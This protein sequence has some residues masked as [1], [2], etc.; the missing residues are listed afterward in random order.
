MAVAVKRADHDAA[1]PR[2]ASRSG[3]GAAARRMP[4]PAWFR[5]AFGAPA[6]P[7][8]RR[9]S[10]GGTQNLRRSGR[11][12]DPRARLRQADRTPV[13][14]RGAGRPAGHPDGGLGGPRQPAVGTARPALLLSLPV[15]RRLPGARCGRGAGDA[16]GR[17]PRDGRAPGRDQPPGGSGRARRRHPRRR[18]LAP[19]GRDAAHPRQHQP[20]APAG[21]FAG[22]E[23]GREHLAVPRGRTIRATAS[24]EP[25]RPSSM[26][27]AR[28]GTH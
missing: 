11:R 7:G 8:A 17:R 16:G 27:A 21:L 9:R 2:A 4:A 12:G 26:H 28:R 10:P 18:R 5:A 19:A 22:I 24:T 25:G 3:D 20:A 14:G 13:A 1:G 15:R 6:P 23:P